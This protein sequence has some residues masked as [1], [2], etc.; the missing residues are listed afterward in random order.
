MSYIGTFD[1]DALNWLKATPQVHSTA[2]RQPGRNGNGHVLGPRYAEASTITTTSFAVSKLAGD[3]LQIAADQ[4][5]GTVQNVGEKAMG[6]PDVITLDV[7]IESVKVTK[8]NAC[9][10]TGNKGYVLIL[11]W[12]VYIPV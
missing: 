1:C 5:C 3:A 12:T 8:S 10:S 7:Y 2:Y 9:I 6:W 4:L 11:S